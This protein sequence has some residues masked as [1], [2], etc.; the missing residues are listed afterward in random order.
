MQ[1]G[2]VE[3]TVLYKPERSGVYTALGRHATLIFPEAVELASLCEE[4]QPALSGVAASPVDE[5]TA[6]P[7]GF[8]KSIN[9]EL[10]T[11]GFLFQGNNLEFLGFSCY[12]KN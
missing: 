12:N 1:K 8:P 3:H 11:I 10:R 9:G 2:K 4:K 7:P 6:P 5:G